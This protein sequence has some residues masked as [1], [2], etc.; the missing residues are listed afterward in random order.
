[1]REIF[2]AV[3][4][5]AATSVGCVDAPPDATARPAAVSQTAQN[6]EQSATLPELPEGQEWVF[7]KERARVMSFP[8][9][10]SPQAETFFIWNFGTAIQHGAPYPSDAHGKLYAVFAQGPA[11]ATHHVPGFD[12]FDHFH[13]I[14]QGV[15]TRT[16]DALL[17]FPGPNFNPATYDPALSVKEMNK[18]IAAGILGAPLLSTQA[19]FD[20]LVL[21]VPITKAD[22]D[23]D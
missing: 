2:G 15:G 21:T 13:I 12:Q 22:L 3:L 11:G 18:Q 1:M 5:V 10:N 9:A 16:L 20:P 4:I 8:G 7:Y 23:D 14:S 6:C 19:G 17:V